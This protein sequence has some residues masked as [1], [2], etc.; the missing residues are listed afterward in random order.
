MV[1]SKSAR[2]LAIVDRSANFD[3]AAK[4]LISA[5]FSFRGKSP[6]APDL[7]LVNE[8]VK[9][10]LLQ[11]LVRQNISAGERDFPANGALE[12]KKQQQSGARA[13]VEDLQR[14]QDAHLITQEANGAI[15]EIGNRS[16]NL[17]QK[18]ITEACLII[19]SMK[20]LDDGIDFV[21]R[22]I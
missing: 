1:S 3:E 10:D 5:R 20:S 13:L 17:L 21:N 19:H 2:V 8:F 6:F 15:V 18:K 9:Q 7:V 14:N 22:Y 12:K 16:T 11:A 4:A